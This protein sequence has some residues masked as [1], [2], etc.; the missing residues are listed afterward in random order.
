MSGLKYI[1]HADLD[2]KKWDATVLNSELPTVFAHSYFLNATSPGWDALIIN[3]YE[4]IFPLT[5]K[6][7]FGMLYLPQPYFTGQLGAFGKISPEREKEFHAY[8]AKKYRLIEIEL[9]ASNHF[10]SKYNQPKNTFVVEYAKGYTFNQNTKRNITKA[11]S[12]G[13][14]VE[15]VPEAEILGLSEKILD[16]FLIKDLGLPELEVRRV[17]VLLKNCIDKKALLTFK[18]VNQNGEAK[19]IGHFV[20]NPRYVVFLKGTNTDKEANS[21]SMHILIAHAIDY[22]KD[23]CECFDFGGGSLH[24]GLAGFY[25]GLGGT[26]RD[27]HLLRINNLPTL[28]KFFKS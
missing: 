1:K 11:Q 7:K 6:K 27:Y 20:F 8:I 10:E 28:L 12:S 16:P 18:T 13:L 14:K 4:S 5:W 3:D 17:G 26:Q 2:F 21:G 25:K 19:A 9:N 23:K 22:F 15:Q 24:E